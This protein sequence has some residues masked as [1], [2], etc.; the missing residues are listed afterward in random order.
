VLSGKDL[1]EEFGRNVRIIKAQTD[2][3]SH[4]DSLLQTPYNINCLNWVLGHIVVGR[5]RVLTRLGRLPLLQKPEAD[6]YRQGSEPI[7]E[8]GP[9][10]LPLERLI[11]LLEEG[12]RQIGETLEQLS[13]EGLSKK[14]DE[15]RSLHDSLRFSCFH[16]TYHTGQTDL[17]RQVAGANDEVL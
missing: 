11:E 17:L 14:L 15:G 8:D 2:G 1:A 3:L 9:G 4:A 10:V 6:R 16:D 5:D 12:Q 7:T 13:E